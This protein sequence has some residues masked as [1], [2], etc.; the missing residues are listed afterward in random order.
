MVPS[1][2]RGA[3][4]RMKTFKDAAEDYSK[5]VKS[6]KNLIIEAWPRM[7][8][9]LAGCALVNIIICIATNQYK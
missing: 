1:T 4:N 2:R 5:A 7:A 9:V 3:I 8:L 6:L